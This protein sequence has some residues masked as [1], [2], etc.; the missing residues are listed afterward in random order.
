MSA[1]SRKAASESKLLALGIPVNAG[2]PLI[3]AEEE[4]TL[5]THE[6]VLQR[7]VALWAVVGKAVLRNETKFTKYIV[8]HGLLPWLSEGER[9]FL[10][11]EQSSER[12]SMQFSWQ[13]EALFFVA[14]CAGLVEAAEVPS[15]ESSVAGILDLFPG[16]HEL[17]ERLR[18][19]IHLRPKAEILARADLLYRL[20]WAVRNAQYTQTAPPAGV[21]GGVVQEWHRA[22]NWVTRYND[23]DNWDH[24][25]TDT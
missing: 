4:V 13:M 12:E 6:E 18:A 14:W 7:L 1:A 11:D 23:E 19:A 20:H 15:E 8:A 5:R 10:I 17:P 2:L 16:P 22:V 25:G 24:V 9:R 3:E 21:N